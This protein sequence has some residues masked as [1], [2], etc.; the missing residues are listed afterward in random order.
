MRQKMT[1]SIEEASAQPTEPT[2]KSAMPMASGFKRPMRSLIGPQ[3]SCATEKPMRKLVIVRAP[4]P[5]SSI[6]ISG[7]AGR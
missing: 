2:R 1:A 3:T 4:L 6:C 5:P 7:I